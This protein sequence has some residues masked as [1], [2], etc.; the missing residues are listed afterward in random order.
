MRTKPAAQH[1]TGWYKISKKLP[2]EIK[3]QTFSA[4][5][6]KKYRLKS[7]RWKTLYP[8]H[9][10]PDVQIILRFRFDTQ[11]CPCLLLCPFRHPCPRL[12]RRFKILCPHKDGQ[13]SVSRPGLGKIISPES[14]SSRKM[15]KEIFS[16][17]SQFK[18]SVRE[19]RF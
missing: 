11:Q 8:G 4:F 7:E 17:E 15:G 13:V 16:R 19:K 6:R 10:F 5:S 2:G 3:F 18:I 12:C 1:S 14:L 9:Q